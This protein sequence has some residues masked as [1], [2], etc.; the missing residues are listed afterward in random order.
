[1]IFAIQRFLEDRFDHRGLSDIDQYA[2]ALANKYVTD[3]RGKSK[4]QFVASVRRIRTVF[5][6]RNRKLNRGAFEAEIVGVLDRHFL[7]KKT[8]LAPAEFPGGVQRERQHL[9][10]QRRN[11]RHLLTEFKSALESRA[12]GNFWLSR[13]AGRLRQRPEEIAQGLLALFF[14]GVLLHGGGYVLRELES[15][16]GYVDLSIALS[17]VLHLIEMKVLRGQFEG[18]A[19]LVVYMK[20]ERRREGWLVVIDPRLAHRRSELPQTVKTA[21]GVVRIVAIDINPIPPSR[22]RHKGGSP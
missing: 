2:V 22:A 11:I 4:P 18:V 15:G 9:R 10:K 13:K 19:Q 20:Q 8:R 16:T 17:R 14:K 21:A 6:K 3:R 5:F 12:V 7:K 1:M